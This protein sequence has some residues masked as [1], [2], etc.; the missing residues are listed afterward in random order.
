[1]HLVKSV[2]IVAAFKA[3]TSGT[4]LLIVKK[5]KLKK[6]YEMEKMKKKKS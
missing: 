1:M 4:K 3:T 5:E 2:I 6:I